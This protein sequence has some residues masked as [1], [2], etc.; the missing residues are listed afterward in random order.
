MMGQGI[1]LRFYWKNYDRIKGFQ[2][3]EPQ[4]L[5]NLVRFLYTNIQTPEVQAAHQMAVQRVK[6]EFRAEKGGMSWSHLPVVNW[7]YLYR[8]HI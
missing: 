7:R 5:V 8:K 3:R 4:N 2:W 6:M 1:R